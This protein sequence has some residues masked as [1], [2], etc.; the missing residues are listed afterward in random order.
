[1]SQEPVCHDSLYRLAQVGEDLG[2]R[3][4]R[5]GELI[6][7]NQYWATALEFN[8]S[9][10]LVP[11]QEPAFRVIN[12]AEPADAPGTIPPD[13]DA[14]AL[15]AEGKWIIFIR[16]AGQCSGGAGHT[17]V[18]RVIASLGG[19]DY[20]VRL[21]D[22][23]ADGQWVD[24]SGADDLTAGNLAE[25]SLGSGA[26]VDLNQRVVLTELDDLQEPPQ[27]RHVFDHPVYAKYLD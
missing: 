4:V 17:M 26:A 23:D 9:G 13:T 7:G 15:D 24:R 11:T 27:K 25:L 12:L 1:M 8:Q 22:I 18:A 10:Q 21:Q 3:L 5:L 20:T 14:V 16:P 19:G 6:A 2:V